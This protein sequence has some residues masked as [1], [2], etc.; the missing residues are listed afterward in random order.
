MTPREQS[1]AIIR[2][3][4]LEYGVSVV[5]ILG[6]DR[7]RRVS[8]ARRCA[9][10]TIRSRKGISYPAIGRIFG[11]DHTTVIYGVRKHGSVGIAGAS[12]GLI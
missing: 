1:I 12:A 7:T 10:A 8:A 4:A 9:Y 5:C 2:E 11:R 3:I 6:R